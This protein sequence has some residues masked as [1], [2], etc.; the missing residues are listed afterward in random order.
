MVLIFPIDGPF[1]ESLL[2][3]EGL[4]VIIVLQAGMIFARKFLRTERSVSNYMLLAWAGIFFSYASVVSIFM[5]ADFY[6][7]GVIN[8]ENVLNIGYLVAGLGATIFTYYAEREIGFKKHLFTI[9][10]VAVFGFLLINAIFPMIDSFILTA[11]GWLIFIFLIFFYIKKFTSKRTE[12]WR[13]N[14][15]SLVVGAVLLILGFGA[16][17]DWS[18]EFFGGFWVRYIG[19]LLMMTGVLCVAALYIGVPSLSEFIWPEK[20]RHFF[21][22]HQSGVSVANYNYAQEG[23]RKRDE[24]L[25]AGG[26]ASISKVIS[27]LIDSEKQLDMVDHGDVI[28][29]F[30]YGK[31]LINVLIVEEPLE[32]L[33]VKLKKFTEAIEI[34][35]EDELAEWDGDLQRFTFLDAVVKA[36]FGQFIKEE[37]K[38]NG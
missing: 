27:S 23:D 24:L 9:L 30:D 21:V 36:N 26:L 15:F 22:I 1:R 5:V 34:I 38:E 31:Y 2:I 18:V 8:R 7:E 4:L 35:Y 25:M 17:A 13:L 6:V 10:L 33:R 11:G 29:L 16:V 3:V 32:I 12:K 20:L 19:D 28:L 14:I 37:G